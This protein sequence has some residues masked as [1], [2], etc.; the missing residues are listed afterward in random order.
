MEEI[1]RVFFKM[2]VKGK[3]YKLSVLRLILLRA[4]E[5]EIKYNFLKFSFK[6]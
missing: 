3:K 6:S 5:E 2:T 1:G 4:I